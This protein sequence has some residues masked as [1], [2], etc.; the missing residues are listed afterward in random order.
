LRS[1]LSAKKPFNQV[2]AGHPEKP[3][4]FNRRGWSSLQSYP[5]ARLLISDNW[6][7]RAATTAGA[8]SART[9]ETN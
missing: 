4:L 8:A 1:W 2:L 3:P 5:L 6:N 7:S 9:K